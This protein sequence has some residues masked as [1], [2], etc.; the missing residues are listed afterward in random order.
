M[1][2]GMGGMFGGGNGMRDLQE[3]RDQR[4]LREKQEF[5]EM[6]ERMHGRSGGM[7]GGGREM[8]RS[9]SE[10]GPDRGMMGREGMGRDMM[11]SDMMGGR[12][13][14]GGNNRDFMRSNSEMM[15]MRSNDR[16]GMDR[17]MDR[18]MEMMD[19]RGDGYQAGGNGMMSQ[20]SMSMSN[21]GGGGGYGMGSDTGGFNRS[22]SYHGGPPSPPGGNDMKIGTW[23]D[24]GNSGSNPAAGNMPAMSNFEIGTFNINDP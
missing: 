7:M 6:R 12:S 14:M 10:I 3:S 5:L 21:G 1:D 13:V 15:G 2:R 23:N 18:R 16:M 24:G 20:R 19:Q 17:G 11:P 4:E 8:T 9:T 22:M